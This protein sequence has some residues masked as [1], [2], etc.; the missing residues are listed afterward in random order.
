M[1][2]DEHRWQFL[3]DAGLGDAQLAPLAGDA[4]NRTYHRLIR[5]GQVSLVLM[6]APPDRDTSTRSFIAIAT[7]L[8]AIGLS[9]P[10]IVAADPGNGFLVLEDLTDAL[11]AR[12][13]VDHPGDEQTLYQNAVDVLI[14]IRNAPCPEVPDHDAASLAALAGIAA[15]WYADG[16][17]DA[18]CQALE[19]HLA[20]IPPTRS[21]ALR[22]F[23]AEN[24]IWLPGRAGVRRT[25][26]LDFQ[27]ACRAHPS[28]DLM[29][30]LEDARRDVTPEVARRTW[31]HYLDQSIQGA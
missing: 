28:Y 19:P 18:F 15:K 4:S 5:P 8:R 9:A 16:D 29:S 17:E 20:N 24:L 3:D 7:H 31:T 25:G 27:D 6:D 13:L 30:L 21:L 14:T 1:N 2:R 22:D 11:F 12:H 23:H 10:E 26:L